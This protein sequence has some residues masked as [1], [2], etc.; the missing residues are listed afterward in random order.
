MYEDWSFEQVEEEEKRRWVWY[1]SKSIPRVY[2]PI[3]NAEQEKESLEE[4][5]EFKEEEEP[6]ERVDPSTLSVAINE[7]G[8]HEELEGFHLP[9]TPKEDERTEKCK[10]HREEVL[11]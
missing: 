10:K 5:K 3:A 8:E 2:Q 11:D 9:S 1:L 6:R 4:S 7:L